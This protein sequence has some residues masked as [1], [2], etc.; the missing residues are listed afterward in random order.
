MLIILPS[1]QVDSVDVT[2][3]NAAEKLDNLRAK[4]AFLG[5]DGLIVPRADE[6]LGEYVPPSAER[7]AWL[8]GFT[9]S[10]GLAAL[11]A[12]Q[13]AVFSD[14]RYTLQL[15]Q[16]TDGSLWQR[17]HMT[18]APAPA[19]LVE[20]GARRIGYDPWLISEEGLRPYVAA[21]LEMVPLEANPIDAIWADRPAPPAMPGV[22]HPLEFAGKASAEKRAEIAAQLRQGRL[23]AAVISDPASVAWLLNLRGADVAFTPFMLG[24]ALIYD[25]ATATLFTDPGKITASLR[26]WLGA[27]IRVASRATLPEALAALA[28]DRVR[29]DTTG[30]P[31]WLAQRLRAAGAEVEAGMDP[32]LLP[33]A[34]KNATE[35]A[36]A[37]VAHLRDGIAITRF[38]HWLDSTLEQ[39]SPIT[40]LS[41][42]ARLLAFRDEMA[43]F[44]GESFPAITGAGEHGAI[45]HYRASPASDRALGR[46]EVYLIDSGGQYL[47]G[48]TD[49]TRTVWTGPNT[50]PDEIC[51]RYTRVLRG[52]I[53]VAKLV[54]P[55]GVT[56]AHI[57]GFARA[58]LWQVGLDYDHGTGHGVGSYLSVHEGPVSLSRAGRPVPLQAGMV[59]SDEPGFYQN[60]AYGMRIEN[61][62]LVQKAEFPAST[63]SFLRF[64]TLSHAPYDRRLINAGLLSPEEIAWVDAYHL[65]VFET[66]A[67]HLDVETR[68]WLAESCAPLL[69]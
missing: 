68:A 17:R 35:Q 66:L 62:V 3:S 45:V 51:D 63:R 18:E 13:A 21:G 40:E 12:T 11:T 69:G 52:H 9:G 46:N 56:G 31:A 58:A 14:G 10:S 30:S 39:G 2:L 24:F 33:K 19:F 8:T 48:T 42:A 23:R 15:Q 43:G 59:L 65:R 54:F 41:A 1:N 67:P 7:L 37:R 34:C 60:G 55:V 16:E 27:D 4:L 38:L 53:A 47:C 36:G 28:G 25:D 44:Q 57:D 20:A 32:C 26:E 5:V 6:H 29:V 64:E 22:I 49:I 61:L 50:P